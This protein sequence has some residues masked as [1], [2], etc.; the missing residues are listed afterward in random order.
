MN[1]RITYR[2]ANHDLMCHEQPMMRPS[3]IPRKKCSIQIGYKICPAS[4]RRSPSL[5]QLC[6]EEKDDLNKVRFHH[7]NTN[8][9]WRNCSYSIKSSSCSEAVCHHSLSAGEKDTKLVRQ[10]GFIVLLSVHSLR[11]HRDPIDVTMKDDRT[12]RVRL[13]GRVTG[14]FSTV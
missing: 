10:I 3:P 9:I 7:H 1:S 4:G 6:T 14:S 8:I 13:P 5:C 2:S 11:L 12:G